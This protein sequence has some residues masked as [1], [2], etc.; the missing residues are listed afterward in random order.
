MSTQ[1]KK[2]KDDMTQAK[3]LKGISAVIATI[4][5]LVITI[6]LAGTAY[7]YISGIFTTQ[8]QGIEVIDN[9]CSATGVITMTIRNIGTNNVT[10][11]TCSQTNPANDA[12]CSPGFSSPINNLGAGESRSF[13]GIDTCQGTSARLCTY[14]LTPSTGRTAIADVQ[15]T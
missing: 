4:L 5:M 2:G 13:P 11:I 9:F 14:R 8:T 7:L 1:E 15:C 3:G 6:A 12:S 10:G